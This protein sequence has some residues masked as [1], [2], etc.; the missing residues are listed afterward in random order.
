MKDRESNIKKYYIAIIF[1]NW[2]EEVD[3]EEDIYK[4]KI[5]RSRHGKRLMRGRKI[6][7]F[8]FYDNWL[9]IKWIG[10]VDERV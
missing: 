6:S 5:V 10:I 2:K 1:S 3:D 8:S 9:A 7:N 4:K